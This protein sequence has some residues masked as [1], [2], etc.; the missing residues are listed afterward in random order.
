MALTETE[1]SICNKLY[2][3][4][5]KLIS[6]VKQAKGS[7][8][9]KKNDL[10]NTLR[11]MIWSPPQDIV[12]ALN[13]IRNGVVLPDS[14]EDAMNDL[15]N[16]LA[17]CNY[18]GALSPISAALGAADSAFNGVNNSIAALIPTIPTFGA[19]E[20]ANQIDSLLRGIGVPGGK[21]LAQLLAL[22]DQILECM[23]AICAGIDPTYN[24]QV[25]IIADDMNGLFSDLTLIDNPGFPDHGLMNYPLLYQG[26]SLNTIQQ[27]TIEAAR[28]GIIGIQTGITTKTNDTMAVIQQYT[29]AGFFA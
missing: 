20:I 18:L 24:G 3:D 5:E 9:Q 4:Y 19:A 7:I 1:Q 21:N 13:T 25:A 16:F 11:S 28:T 26:L 27:S 15:K 6:P 23:S 12:D 22:A 2:G 17:R 8:L 10:L 29:K 14:T